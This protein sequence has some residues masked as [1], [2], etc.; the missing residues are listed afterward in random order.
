[1]LSEE[2]GRLQSHSRSSE[3]GDHW[4]L[5]WTG[6][7]H[8]LECLKGSRE[9]LSL[10]M[11]NRLYYGMDNLCVSEAQEVILQRGTFVD[12]EIIGLV[13]KWKKISGKLIAQF[14]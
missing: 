12:Q 8:C 14:E 6:R 2:E 1:M 7:G 11:N 10:N 3:G 13:A 5:W 4:A 9:N